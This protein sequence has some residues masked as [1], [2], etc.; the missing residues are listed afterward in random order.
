MSRLIRIQS[1]VQDVAEAI[2]AALGIEVEIVDNTLTVVGG[3]ARYKG[4]VGKKEEFGRVE[5]DFLYARTLRSGK[6]FVVDDPKADPRY[7]PS[8][9]DGTTKELGEI[10]SPIKLGG[11][12]IG[13]IGLA[14]FTADQ[15]RHLKD[16]S[17]AI[18]LFLKH[19]GRLLAAKVSES[20]A[21]ERLTMVSRE[22]TTILET[23]HEGALAI[24]EQGLVTHCNSTAEKLLQINRAELL[25]KP[26]EG[27]WA[28]A[29]ALE[30]LRN[31]QEYTE[32]EEIYHSGHRRMH[33]IVTVRL[34]PGKAGPVG[35]VISF[36]DIA[37]ARRLIYDLSE[38]TAAYT[39]DD[40]IG[41]STVIRQVKAQALRV[42]SGH[43][44]VLITGESGT[45]KEVFARA[46]H[47]AS[48]RHSGPFI[49]INCGAIPEALLESELFGYEGGAFTG[50]RKEGKAG[51]FELAD[52]GT[53]FL[54]EIGEMPLHLQVK[55]LHV[56][57][58]R[59]VERVGG[60]K[61][62]PVDV[63][64]IAASNRDLEQMMHE[65]KFR[66]DLYF[67]LSVIPLHIPP[68]KDRK[69]DIPKLVHHCLE[70]Y[71]K[72]LNI[73]F[74]G[75]EPEAMESLLLYHWPGNVR[76]LENTIEYAVNMAAGGT[77]T[78][79]N[80]PPRFRHSSQNTKTAGAS[81]KNKVKEFEKALLEEYL[82]RFG[83][84]YDAKNA[85]ARELSVS[86]A[87]LYRKLAELGLSQ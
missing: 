29:P 36:R 48:L 4:K 72:M 63:R 73:R 86:R 68:L 51:K 79:M 42:A 55:L 69:E 6:A 84:T 60:S 8:S 16:S 34:V 19:M 75:V 78:M 20:E 54:D 45:G 87:T 70:R 15:N 37:E 74:S 17:A 76:E 12:S 77:L 2:A 85:I 82:E 46:I 83:R 41:G 39:F 49:S 18:L 28:K 14:A 80:L 40:I 62:L 3:S 81:L 65:G 71:G 66:H 59:E 61:N 33:L 44:T 24:N 50:A 43:S 57:Q 30:A 11:E 21:M 64:I 13:V 32:K 47:H 7:D 1:T 5:G 25:G 27:F 67:R 22:L 56:L 10:C 35:A 53:I 31:G 38:Y 58:N 52:G 23:I 26:L 9:L